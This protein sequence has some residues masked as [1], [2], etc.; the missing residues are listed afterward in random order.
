[1]KK[2]SL[3]LLIVLIV[4]AC[5][6]KTAKKSSSTI[7][8]NKDA[9]T[10]L[11]DYIKAVGGQEKIKTV[12]SMK[13]VMQGDTPMGRMMMTTIQ[14]MPDRFA[15]MVGANGA[16]IQKIVIKGKKGMMSGMAGTKELTTNEV[17]EYQDQIIPF[18]EAH[19]TEMGYT[20]KNVGIED[21]DGKKA[22]KLQVI[23][24]KGNESW[25]YY[26]TETALKVRRYQEKEGK[27]I[28][29]DFS[30]YQEVDGLKFP[31]TVTAKGI[32]PM[33]T[34]TLEVTKLEVNGTISDAI[35][36]F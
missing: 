7:L 36:T 31:Y 4:G 28:T 22:Y 19:Y 12:K 10:I 30:N 16:T 23:D 29:Y 27:K 3:Y 6:P 15:L 21:I 20:I 14:A 25:E 9:T 26:D 17:E 8:E 2:I 35:F 24:T 32:M 33:M 18:S 1:M 5:T 34:I 13:T 11:A